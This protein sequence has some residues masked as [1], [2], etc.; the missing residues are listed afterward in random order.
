MRAFQNCKNVGAMSSIGRVMGTLVE[1]W[2][3]LAN[4]GHFGRFWPNFAF[5][6]RIFCISC[7]PYVRAFQ[8]VPKCSKTGVIWPKMAKN[9]PKMAQNGP[10]WAKMGQNDPKWPKLAGADQN[11]PKS[12]Q[13]VKI[14][15]MSSTKI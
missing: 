6:F 3:I 7:V 12:V 13:R 15:G 9:G 2:P 11:I 14:W 10:K 1:F 4:F 8:N 5:F